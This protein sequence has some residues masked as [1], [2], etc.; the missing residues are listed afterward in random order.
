MV[1]YREMERSESPR[2]PPAAHPIISPPSLISPQPLISP[3]QISA[4]MA[5]SYP[6]PTVSPRSISPPQ[7]VS[8]VLGARSCSSPQFTTAGSVMSPLSP[9]T[10]DSSSSQPPHRR[11]KRHKESTHYRESDILESPAVY[12][13]SP[14]NDK[15]CISKL[16]YKC[17]L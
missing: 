12:S 3:Q 14:F 7:P 5:R 8:S 11:S 2:V 1:Q 10:S 16:S 15:V 6:Q 17:I 9:V 4:Q 13:R